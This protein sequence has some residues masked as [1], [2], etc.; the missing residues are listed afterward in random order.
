MTKAA[1]VPKARD[2]PVTG[3]SVVPQD[4]GRQQNTESRDLVRFLGTRMV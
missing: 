2:W 4:V 3:L 1:V